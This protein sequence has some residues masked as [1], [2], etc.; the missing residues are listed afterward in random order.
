M[1]RDKLTKYTGPQG[2][3]DKIRQVITEIVRKERFVLNKF[4]FV[5]LIVCV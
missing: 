4:E 1:A 5:I 2:R 3:I